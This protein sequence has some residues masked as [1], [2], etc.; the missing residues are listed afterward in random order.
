M[1]RVEQLMALVKCIKLTNVDAVRV[2]N[3]KEFPTLNIE[4]KNGL[5]RQ[6]ISLGVTP[7]PGKGSLGW[8]CLYWRVILLWSEACLESSATVRLEFDSL[9]LRR[10]DKVKIAEVPDPPE[11]TKEILEQIKKEGEEW[12]KEFE[13]R[14]RKMEI[15]R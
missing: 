2:K 11:L 3:G 5:G 14:T 9:A 1:I 10:M 13:Q 12:H 8:V 15:M 4:N 7:K 6:V